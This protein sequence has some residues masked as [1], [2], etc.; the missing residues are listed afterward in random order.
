MKRIT[1]FLIAAFFATSGMAQTADEAAAM[2]AWQDFMTPGEVHRMMAGWDGEWTTT[3]KM[4]MEPG[5]PP[6][7]TTGTCVNKMLLGG[8][9][10]ESRFS[11]TAMNMPF[12][13]IGTTAYDN[14]K[15][16]FVTTWVDNMGTGIMMLRG[17]WNAASKSMTLSGTCTDPSSG[18]DMKVREVYTIQDDN[19]QLMEMWMTDPKTK[20]EFK[21]MEVAFRRK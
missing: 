6:Q 1:L 5:A 2:K 7:T 13:G 3:N 21:S 9:Y 20:K 14:A 16:Q 12:E 18:K 8:R 19:N 11:T 10:Q 4:W 15:K 17:S